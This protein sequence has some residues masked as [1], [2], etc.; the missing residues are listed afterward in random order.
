[1]TPLEALNLLTDV[2][3]DYAAMVRELNRH[4]KLA[5]PVDPWSLPLMERMTKARCDLAMAAGCNF[6]RNPERAIQKA[7]GQ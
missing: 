2:Q 7:R 1:M 4:K 3:Q 6:V 5:N